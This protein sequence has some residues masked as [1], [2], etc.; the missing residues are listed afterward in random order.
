M[1]RKM[2]LNKN[3]ELFV[4]AGDSTRGARA[5]LCVV[6]GEGYIGEGP[7]RKGPFP[8]RVFGYFLHEQKVT[9]VRAGKAR[10]AASRIAAP[11]EETYFSPTRPAMGESGPIGAIRWHRRSEMGYGAGGPEKEAPPRS[12]AAPPVKRDAVTATAWTRR[13]PDRCARWPRQTWGPR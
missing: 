8:M 3:R 12:A 10:E 2:V 4:Y 11:G 13:S 7:H 5:P 9:R 1:S 6:V